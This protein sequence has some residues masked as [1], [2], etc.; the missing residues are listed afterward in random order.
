MGIVTNDKVIS[1]GWHVGSQ[2]PIDDRLVFA[3]SAALINLG[4]S[5]VEAYR[6]YEGMRVWVIAT[7]SEYEW[8]ESALGAIRRLRILQVFT[9]MEFFTLIGHLTGLKLEVLVEVLVEESNLT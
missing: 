6:Y 9:Q 3:D 2:T 8:K 5:D 7:R 4:A 1:E